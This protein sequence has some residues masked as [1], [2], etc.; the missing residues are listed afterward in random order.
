MSDII[1]KIDWALDTIKNR[2][3]FGRDEEGGK[4]AREIRAAGVLKDCKKE[5]LRLNEQ[6]KQLKGE[7]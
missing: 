3:E 5:I 2:Y 6:I 7:Q 4:F 1:E